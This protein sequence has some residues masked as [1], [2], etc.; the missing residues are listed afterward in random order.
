MIKYEVDY[1]LS[2]EIYD[3]HNDLIEGNQCYKNIFNVYIN[4][5][6]KDKNVTYCIGYAIKNDFIYRHG[7]IR[8]NDKIIDP[9]PFTY[10]NE[11][12]IRN[13]NYM[14]I[15]EFSRDQYSDLFLTE[16]TKFYGLEDYLAKDE[17]KFIEKH[18]LFEKINVVDIMNLMSYYY[19]KSLSKIGGEAYL[20]LNKK[21]FSEKK[22]ISIEEFMKGK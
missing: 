10:G 15:K 12:E 22:F 9:T 4:N 21:V 16:K 5:I 11:D 3:N 2:K 7:F 19:G 14:I 17:A 13:L 1:E 18:N 20:D 6:L 8:L